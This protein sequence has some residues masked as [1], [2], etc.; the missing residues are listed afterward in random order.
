MAVEKDKVLAAIETKFKGKSISKT[1]KQNL[2]AKWA[3]KIETEDDIDTYI[4]DREE[5]I[6]EAIS[7]ADRRA[8]DAAKKASE[9]AKEA[10]KEPKD[11]PK[12]VELPDDTPAWAKTLIENNKAL[13]AKLNGFEQAQSQKTIAERF[14]SHEKL[15]GIPELLFKG[16]IPQTEDD[17]EAAVEELATDFEALAKEQNITRFGNDKPGGAGHKPEGGKKQA[18]KEEI[19][20]L[21]EKMNLT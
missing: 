14:K 17:F 19:D 13:E 9:K 7:E 2:A 8:V 3:E 21:A 5:I 4:E 12:E 18:T 11:E 6:T 15:K 20:A 10:G 1:F 16:R